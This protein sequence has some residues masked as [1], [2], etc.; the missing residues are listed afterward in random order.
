[1]DIIQKA[2]KKG[3]KCS[4]N[5]RHLQDIQAWLRDKHDIHVQP[6]IYSWS[7]RLYQFRIHSSN[8]Y[9]NSKD[10]LDIQITG[11]HDEMLEKGILV[12]LDML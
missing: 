2:T 10:F 4:N 8:S 5:G 6:M 11:S 7:E 3:C 1:M 12:A 9:I